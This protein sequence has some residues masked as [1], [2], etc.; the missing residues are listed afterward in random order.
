MEDFFWPEPFRSPEPAESNC[1][2]GVPAP[3]FYEECSSHD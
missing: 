2:E 1:Q 3:D